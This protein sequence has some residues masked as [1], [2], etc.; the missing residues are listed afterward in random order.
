MTSTTLTGESGSHKV[1][2]IAHRHPSIVTAARLGWAAKG[3][4]YLLLGVLAVPIA[5]DGLGGSDA[6]AGG[7]EAS[8]TG[9]V[10]RL[11]E[12][13]LGSVALWAVAIGLAL[14]VVWRLASILLPADNTA[15]AWLTR[16]GYLVSALVYA[17]LAWTAVTFAQHGGASNASGT[18]SESEDAK[19]ER[20]TRELMDKSGGRWLVALVGAAVVGIGAYFVIKGLRATFRDELEPGDVGPVGHES[21][22]ML[23]RVGWVGRGIMMGLVGWLLIQAAAHFDPEEAKGIDGALRDATGSTFGSLLVLFVAAALIVYGAFCVISAPRQR[24]TSAD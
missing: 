24:L 7:Q 6:G 8:Q 2:Q 4:V 14:Y 23:G 5:L 13:S 10:A 20:F 12:S 11:G 19:V 17:G 15:K 9:A 22:V 1:E 18:G 21:I 3:V 16:A